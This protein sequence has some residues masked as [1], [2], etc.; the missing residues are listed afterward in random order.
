MRSYGN[1]YKNRLILD[2]KKLKHIQVESNKMSSN[3]NELQNDLY[4][5]KIDTSI[6]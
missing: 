3:V 4:A 1:K 2:L 6:Y 5:G